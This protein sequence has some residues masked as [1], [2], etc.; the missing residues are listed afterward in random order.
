M[1]GK[2]RILMEENNE[3]DKM[4]N[5]VEDK[6]KVGE[7]KSE[8]VKLTKKEQKLK[9]KQEKLRL[10]EEKKKQREGM[11]AAK[12]SKWI[13]LKRFGK[14]CR[15]VLKVTKK[16]NKQEFYT[17]VKISALGMAIM[18]ILGFAITLIKELLL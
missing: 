13:K 10:K 15:R 11:A 2:Q 5:E 4:M 18:G 12:E 14:E 6:I 8:D 9:L 16:P 7:I 3:V 1:A 17:V